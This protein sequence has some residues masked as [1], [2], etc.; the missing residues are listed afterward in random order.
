MSDSRP[1]AART[2]AFCERF[3]LRLPVLLA[4]MAGACP[5]SLSIAVANAGG[6]GACGALLMQPEAIAAWM[7]EFRAGSDGPCQLNLWIPD[8]PPARDPA[9]EAALRRFLADWG[10]EVPADAA[11]A[12]IAGLRPPVPGVAR[13]G[14]ARDLVDH[15]AVSAGIRGGAEASRHRLVRDRDD[16]CRSL[17]R[18]SGGRRRDRGTGRGGRR[19]SRR[20]RCH[21]GGAGDGRAVRAAAAGG[22]R[23]LRPGDRHRRHRRCARRR[24]GA[25]PGGQRGADRQRIAALPGGEA[26]PGLGGGAGRAAAGGHDDHARLQRPSRAGGRHRLHPRRR[27]PGRAAAGAVPGAARP[28]RADAN[29]GRA[30]AGCAAHAG[31]GGPGGWAGT[32][33]NLRPRRCVGF[34][35]VRAR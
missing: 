11:D 14:T 18:R 10:P 3:G 5:P 30:R 20:L 33:P 35:R 8:P 29:R 16:D 28:D 15:G 2:A 23:G 12:S 21:G 4:P 24:G 22:G 19:P 13:C 27:R 6:M 7:A 17:R 26:E 9:Q 32:S 1:A 25:D 34:G 31:L